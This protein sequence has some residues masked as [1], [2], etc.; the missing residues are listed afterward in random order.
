MAYQYKS[1]GDE[2]LEKIRILES[3]LDKTI[4]VLEPIKLGWVDLSQDDIPKNE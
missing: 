4:I 1:L 2:Q 3:K